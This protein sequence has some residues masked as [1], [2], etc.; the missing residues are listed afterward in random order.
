MKTYVALLRGI[1]AGKERRV[2][3]KRLKALFESLRYTSV[4]TYINSG[5]V[6][7]GSD[8]NLADIRNDLEANLK[9]EFGFYI[10]TLIKTQREMKKIADSIPKVWQNDDIQR[11]DVAYL[12]KEIDSKKTLKEIPV[13]KEYI[14]IRY[15][16]GAIY[17]NINRKNYNKSQ[18]NKLIGHKI[19]Q[20]MTIRNV[21]TA[22]FLAG[23]K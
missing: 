17:W 10:P 4:S 6:I 16:P 20:L 8:N 14:D 18:L 11:S 19:Y 9:R 7:F 21:N 5:N 23:Y 22:R 15:T 12:F 1:N 3:M 2:D 13:K